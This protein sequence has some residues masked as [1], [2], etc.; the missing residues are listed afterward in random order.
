MNL[1]VSRHTLDV[2]EEASA[3]SFAAALGLV[4]LITAATL[5]YVWFVA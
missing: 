2:L 4:S 1:H 5:I 3:A